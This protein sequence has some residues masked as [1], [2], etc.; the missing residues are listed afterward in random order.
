MNDAG[1]RSTALA[2]TNQKFQNERCME[3]VMKK[4]TRSLGLV[5]ISCFVLMFICMP[6]PAY[7]YIDPGT[8]SLILQGI[9]AALITGLAF[10]RGV[11]EKIAGFF[12]G[13]KGNKSNDG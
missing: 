12:K 2:D 1:D 8:G 4:K 11:R 13:N 7:A 10:I 5:L 3:E 6:T 9:A